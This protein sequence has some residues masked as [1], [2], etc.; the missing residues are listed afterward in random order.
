MCDNTLGDLL[1]PYPAKNRRKKVRV[2]TSDGLVKGRIIDVDK[3][4]QTVI[5]AP[6]DGPQRSFKTNTPAFKGWE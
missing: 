2:Q 3:D 1:G 5:I 6:I 4:K